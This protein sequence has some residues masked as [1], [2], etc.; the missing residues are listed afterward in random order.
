MLLDCDYQNNLKGYKQL[1]KQNEQ[2]K[3]LNEKTKLCNALEEG[4]QIHWQGN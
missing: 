2:P 4:L 3:H 1:G